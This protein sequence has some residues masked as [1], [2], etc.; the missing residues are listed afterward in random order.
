MTGGS[1]VTA[2]IR[3]RAAGGTVSWR[4]LS[5][6][7]WEDVWWERLSE[8]RER[9]AISTLAGVRTIRV[10]VFALSKAEAARLV[11]AFGGQVR[12]MTRAQQLL[13]VAVRAPIKVRDRLVVV[14][15]GEERVG[16]GRQ[17]L[18]IPAGMAFGTGDHATT[19]TCLRLLA[20]V[21]DKL[22]GRR[23]EM[24]D[25]GCGTGILA[26]AGRLLGARRVLAGD[27]DPDSVRTAKENACANRIEQ[28]TVRRLDVLRWQP[29]RRWEVVVA[30]M[31]SRIL[32]EIA[33][34]LAAATAP[35]GALIFSG[36]LRVQEGEVVA[37][38][39]AQ[40]FRIERI[41][42]KGKWVTGLAGK[43]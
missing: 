24:L 40:R 22:A 7:K 9:L 8:F 27:F 12:T 28:V 10:E 29:T 41:V 33:P 43:E 5:A 16:G 26:L 17:R 21:S 42:R 18:V 39:R 4:K 6:A 32:V 11:R 2:K 19:A 35:G 31:Y 20:D 30:N 14:A 38:L 3:R 25:L 36:V 23:W 15:T 37:A 13:A 34:K 1:P